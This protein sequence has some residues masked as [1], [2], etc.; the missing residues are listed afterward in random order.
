MSWS[1]PLSPPLPPS[2]DVRRNPREEAWFQQCALSA[3]QKSD[4]RSQG[5]AI[6][7]GI[8]PPAVLNDA[9]RSINADMA[10]PE[11]Y[12]HN[13]SLFGVKI[14]TQE[15][16]LRLMFSSPVFAQVWR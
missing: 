9:L 5:F 1:C 14:S 4:F 11:E 13:K 16:I 6:F 7:R 15:E 10:K 2:Q 3:S 12:T 8:I